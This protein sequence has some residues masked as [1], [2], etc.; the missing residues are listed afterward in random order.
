V[1]YDLAPVTG[2]VQRVRSRAGCGAIVLAVLL[3]GLAVV[4]APAPATAL[5][6]PV[7]TTTTIPTGFGGMA[8][9]AAHSQV[10]VS[11][12]TSGTITALD[13]NGAIL[14]TV[15]G[16]A[17]PGS[18][19]VHGDSLYVA[20]RNGGAIDVFDTATR[21][22][23]ATLA[24]GLL[25]Q[26]G[27]LVFAGDQL[28]TTVGACFSGAVKLASVDPVTGD[29]DSFTMPANTQLSYCAGLAA[30]PWDQSTI[31]GWSLGLS[32]P[33]TSR[34]DVSTGTP[35]VQ[36]TQRE[37]GGTEVAFMPGGSTFV[38][39]NKEYRVGDLTPTGIM[40][41]TAGS[42]VATTPGQGGLVAMGTWS[43]YGPDLW[44]YR[45]GQPGV[46]VLT[47]DFGVTDEAITAGGLAFSPD[48]TRLFSVSYDN[49][50]GSFTRFNVFDLGTPGVGNANGELTPLTPARILDTRNGTGGR[51]G[52]LGPGETFDLQVTG[53]GGVPGA[54]VSAV[55]L[56]VTATEPTEA[57]YLTVWPTGNP[58]PTVS[59]LNFTPGATVPNLV[60]VK[61]GNGGRV[62]I[63]NDA[64]STHV[65]VDVVGFYADGSGPAGSRFHGVTPSRLFDTRNGSGGVPLAKRGPG[66]TLHVTVTGEDGVP[67]SG[68]TAVVLNVTATEPTAPSFL[69]VYPDDVSR[70][71]ASNLNVVPGQTVPN[72]VVVRVPASGVIDFY[73]NAGSTH[74]LADVVGYY[75]G[76]KST[77]AGRLIAGGPLRLVD[78]RVSSPFPGS[79]KVPGGANLVLDFSGSPN[80]GQLG[81]FV[82]NV[83]VTEPTAPG[84][85][86]VYPA[87][88]PAPA[89]SSLNFVPGLTVANAAALRVGDNG[90]VD[91]FNLAGATHVIVDLFGIF[92][93]A[94]GVGAASVDVGDTTVSLGA[95]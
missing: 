53:K 10:F 44:V 81:G 25:D 69:T 76:D 3:G 90:Q 63:V 95:G 13:F 14:G 51:S 29:V 50:A 23:T 59:N 66:S 22:R 43:P 58:R 65:V 79:G 86:T 72:L 84:Y 91:V 80:F 4:S 37:V 56:N 16:E 70:P 5:I 31:I 60:T 54:G 88:P 55:V 49:Y 85:V 93:S 1:A 28:W 78:T 92:T 94:E 17:G 9:D 74:L 39:Y 35:V 68:V 73:N 7:V 19:V 89:T 47:H 33:T 75:D 57:S 48:A 12:P 87:P 41:P 83:T 71:T 27:P 45:A 61:V 64:G 2:F 24:Q 38:T 52:P 30:D 34:I 62:T 18:M 40:Y 6:D 67:A 21:V 32:P 20:L 36:V 82:L 77:D 11:S 8:V 42:A 46:N 15:S 26:P